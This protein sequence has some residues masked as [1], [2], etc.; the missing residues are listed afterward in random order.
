MSFRGLSHDVWLDH[1]YGNTFPKHTG[2]VLRRI[3]EK[4]HKYLEVTTT[5]GGVSND[6]GVQ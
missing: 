3:G 1:D 6:D 4:N 2:K 5:F